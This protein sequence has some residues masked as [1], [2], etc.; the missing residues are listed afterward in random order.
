[1]NLWSTPPPFLNPNCINA[2]SHCPGTGQERRSRLASYASI[3][4]G[5]RRTA[6]TSL[7]N[8]GTTI[9]FG[10]HF[11]PSCFGKVT[12][13]SSRHGTTGR[14]ATQRRRNDWNGNAWWHPRKVR[15]MRRPMHPPKPPQLLR[16]EGSDNVAAPRSAE[17]GEDHGVVCQATRKL[18][19][20]LAGMSC[21]TILYW[22]YEAMHA[23]GLYLLHIQRKRPLSIRGSLF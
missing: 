9:P 18:A 10:I 21:H 12:P 8:I 13:H 16:A 15:S 19:R 2:T 22:M 17:V 23:H 20:Q 7:V 3:S 6:L 5:L 14:S 1:M 4:S 11:V